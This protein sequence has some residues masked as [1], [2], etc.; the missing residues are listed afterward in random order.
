MGVTFVSQK[1]RWSRR[2]P[3]PFVAVKDV[4][5]D[6]QPSS[7]LGVV[8]E[9]GSGKTTLARAILRAIIP[10]QGQALFLSAQQGQ[11][12][13][14]T[15]TEQELKPLR[16]EMQMVF[17][18]PFSSLNPRMKVADILEEPMIIHDAG[19]RSQRNARARELLNLVGLPTSALSRY[20]HAFS[21][22]QRQRIAIARAL[23]LQPSLLVCDESVSALD[24]S[25]QAQVINL[26]SDLQAE[27]GLAIIFV[28]HDLAV[29]RHLCDDVLVMYRG[30]VV[31][32]GKTLEIFR[33]PASDYTRL[34]LSAI[35]S[36]DPDVRLMPLDRATL[37]L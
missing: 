33:S 30:Q 19:N 6:L 27:L 37:N 8:G 31:E 13:L 20:P 15:L 32:Q 12:D 23:I 18:D 21:G 5:F 17:Q 4:S 35:P 2:A 28:A 24:L 36:P 7:I 3:E 29:V 25:V 22:G 9:S 26:L 16:R 11:V 34:L 1:S 14:A 10:T